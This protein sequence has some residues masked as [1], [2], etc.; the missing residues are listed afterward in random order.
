VRGGIRPASRFEIEMEDPVRDRR[1]AHA[2]DVVT[3]PMV[4]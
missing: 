4:E 3:L 1:I 2:Y